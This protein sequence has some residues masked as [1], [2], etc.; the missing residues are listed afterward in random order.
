MDRHDE[1]DDKD[2]AALRFQWG[3]DDTEE[4]RVF[5][6]GLQCLQNNSLQMALHCFRRAVEMQ[7]NNPY[8]LS[9]YG[10][11]LARAE[12]KWDE[13]ERICIEAVKMKRRQPQLYV[14][15]A[16]L[17]LSAGKRADAVDVLQEAVQYEPGDARL[18][19]MMIRVGIRRP[20]VFSF[21]ERGHPVNKSL[22]LIRHRVLKFF[23]RYPTPRA[24]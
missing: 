3:T 12:R 4:I 18:N 15:L 14:N 1:I 8:F 2:V 24:A 19:R 11:L 21:L 16:E 13:G 6:Q 9:Y 20:P 23:H 7:N 5:K 22:G 10:L 17:Y